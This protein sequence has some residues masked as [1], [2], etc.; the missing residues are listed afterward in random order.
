MTHDTEMQPARPMSQIVEPKKKTGCFTRIVVWI[1]VIVVIV[2]GLLL[3][4]YRSAVMNPTTPVKQAATIAPTNSAAP[5]A[6]PASPK[7]TRPS[8]AEREARFQKDLPSLLDEVKQLGGNI[9]FGE[10]GSADTGLSRIKEQLGL[11]ADSALLNRPDIRKL[12]QQVGAS[13][14]RVSV[15]RRAITDADPT[16]DITVVR[17]SWSSEGF[18]IVAVWTVTLKNTNPAMRYSDIE[19]RTEYSAASGTTV[20]NGSGKILDIIG[21]RQTRTFKVNDGFVNS[22]A[23]RASF[24]IVDA[25]K[26]FASPK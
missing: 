5:V 1:V 7:D 21:P 24:H 22:Q 16:T 20:G 19:Y 15:L 18:G 23:Q 17:A 2:F 4:G 14:A 11:I 9:R 8:L 6:A 3:V 12:R 26:E 10:L 25:T 13:E